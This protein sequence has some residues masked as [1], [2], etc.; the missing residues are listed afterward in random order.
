MKSI[1]ATED[2]VVLCN[3]CQT[4]FW[5]KDNML[6]RVPYDFIAM[7][8]V[9][10]TRAGPENVFPAECCVCGADP[11]R[12]ESY[13]FERCEMIPQ[14]PFPAKQALGEVK[15]PYC[16]AHWNGAAITGEYPEFFIRFRS[17]SYFRVFCHVNGL[18]P[19]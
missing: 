1:V 18:T 9:F 14:A 3:G 15:I 11:S 2:N 8:L 4:Y 5:I 16:D 12:V 7:K 13:Q 17:Y 19:E 6:G 10:R